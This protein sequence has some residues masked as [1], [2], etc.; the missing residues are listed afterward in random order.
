MRATINSLTYNT[1]TADEL[2]SDSGG[3]YCNDFHHW[4]ETLYRTK[5]GNHFLH[6]TGGA[7]SRYSEPSGDGNSRGGGSA[8]VP[9]TEAEAL[10]WCEEHGC[11]NAI[12]TYFNH[13]TEEA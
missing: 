5:K 4:E 2:A 11:E 12:D 3:G 10:E 9:L 13:L 7:C 6:G 8:I 1:D